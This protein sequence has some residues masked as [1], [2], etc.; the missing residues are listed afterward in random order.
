MTALQP[1]RRKFD[2]DCAFFSAPNHAT[3]FTLQPRWVDYCGW[4]E[5]EKNLAVPRQKKSQFFWVRQLLTN[6]TIMADDDDELWEKPAWAKGGVALKKTGKAEQM[7]G[8]G[9][10]AAPITFVSTV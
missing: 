9:N 3:R 1:D 7:K 10:L 6:T 8:D 5:T 2:R 4:L